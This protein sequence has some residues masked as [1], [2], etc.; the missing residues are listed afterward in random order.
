MSEGK[1]AGYLA[2]GHDGIISCPTHQTISQATWTLFVNPTPTCL[3]Y[4]DGSRLAIQISG[5]TTVPDHNSPVW[6]GT[7]SPSPYGETASLV[8]GNY[9]NAAL[10]NFSSPY[11]AASLPNEG[12][13]H[14]IFFLDVIPARTNTAF[15]KYTPPI[16]G[17]NAP[18][19]SIQLLKIPLCDVMQGVCENVPLCSYDNV[20]NCNSDSNCTWR[21]V[22][23]YMAGD[24]L[25]AGQSVDTQARANQIQ[26]E[27]QKK[28]NI[29]EG[30][31]CNLGDGTPYTRVVTIQLDKGK[32]GWLDCWT[33]S[34]QPNVIDVNYNENTGIC[35]VLQSCDAGGVTPITNLDCKTNCSWPSNMPTNSAFPAC[36]VGTTP[37][38]CPVT[39]DICIGSCATNCNPPQNSYLEGQI[40]AKRYNCNQNTF[41]CYL[42]P[43]GPINNMAD[44]E[45]I[46]THVL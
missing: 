10:F 2:V 29:Q 43:E 6:I 22:V 39:S 4:S 11:L 30:S 27:L 37:A 8:V 40:A 33:R 35:A 16:T 17:T 34:A 14:S 38:S 44:C 24:D 28:Y 23:Q 5:V 20:M 31:Y 46:C 45:A 1:D 21:Q 36:T 19:I 9:S 41:Q 25:P 32:C 26:K 7:S 12:L 3:L 18:S 15:V 13:G 42:D